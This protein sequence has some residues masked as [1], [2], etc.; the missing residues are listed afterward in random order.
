MRVAL[1]GW[2]LFAYRSS[3]SASR[4]S[5]ARSSSRPVARTPLLVEPVGEPLAVVLEVDGVDERCT[6]RSGSGAAF[7]RS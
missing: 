3:R 5:R 6:S 1:A 2:R 4:T 7:G